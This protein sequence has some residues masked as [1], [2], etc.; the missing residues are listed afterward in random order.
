MHN[1]DVLRNAFVLVFFYSSV[2]TDQQCSDLE[3]NSM[4]WL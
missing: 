2:A 1:S 4:E 3:L